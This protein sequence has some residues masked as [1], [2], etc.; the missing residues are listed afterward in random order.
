MFLLA[1]ALLIGLDNVTDGLVVFPAMAKAQLDENLPYL[2]TETIIMKLVGH[3][4]SRQEAHE[5]IRVLSRET[6]HAVKV[7]GGKNDLIDR[8]K[9]DDFFVSLCP[10]DKARLVLTAYTLET[11]MARVRWPTRSQAVHRPVRRDCRALRGTRRSGRR[12]IGKI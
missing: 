4:I 12:Q 8:M 7:E 11:H 3:G 9:K 2:A 5:R 6:I 10:V 1:D